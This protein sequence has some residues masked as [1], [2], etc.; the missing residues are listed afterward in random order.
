MTKPDPGRGRGNLLGHAVQHASV[1]SAG[2]QRALALS[3]VLLCAFM[4]PGV[5]AANDFPTIERVLF[6]EACV[7]DHTDRQRQEMLY[8]CSCALD[9]LAAEFPYDDYVELSTANDAG[10][11]AGE[12]G[13][14]IRESDQGR[15]M[16]KRF[17]AARA[18]AY[19]SCMIQ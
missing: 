9:A 14:A 4:L 16:S 5:A 18:K 2:V 7:R 12:R 19:K 15:D 17:K 6:V 8:K 3:L 13:T 1:R 10:Q 11:V